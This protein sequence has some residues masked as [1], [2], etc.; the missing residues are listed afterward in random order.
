M[1]VHWRCNLDLAL[2]MLV[3]DDENYCWTERPW[4]YFSSSR[5]FLKTVRKQ[6]NKNFSWS[7][8]PILENIHTELGPHVIHNWWFFRIHQKISYPLFYFCFNCTAF[9][10]YPVSPTNISKKSVLSKKDCVQK[11]HKR[12]QKN[13][14]CECRKER[15]HTMCSNMHTK[16][17][18]TRVTEMAN[19]GRSL[20]L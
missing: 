15:R 12:V 1:H 5:R 2:V 11:V 10:L 8:Q 14:T 17:V 4:M 18:G 9:Q 3:G 6:K 7:L 19:V 20:G 13:D 16:C